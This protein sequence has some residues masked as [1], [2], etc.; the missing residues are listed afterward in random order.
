MDR[1]GRAVASRASVSSNEISNSILFN[2]IF[3]LLREKQV[4]FNP[5]EPGAFEKQS[6]D[7]VR[8]GAILIFATLKRLGERSRL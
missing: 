5:P 4:L 8:N 7:Q 1:P 6:T 3:L 2:I